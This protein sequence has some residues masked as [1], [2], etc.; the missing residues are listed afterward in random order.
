MPDR[1]Q[2]THP[3]S[4]RTGPGLAPPETIAAAVVSAPRRLPHD[5]AIAQRLRHGLLRRPLRSGGADRW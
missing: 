3:A 5:P 4:T 1:E 2:Q